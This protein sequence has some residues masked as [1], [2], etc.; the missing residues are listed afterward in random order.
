VAVRPLLAATRTD[1]V[2]LRDADAVADDCAK[3]LTFRATFRPAVAVAVLCPD[4]EANRARTMFGA[5]ETP[6]TTLICTVR[7]LLPTVLT[8]RLLFA[9]TETDRRTVLL[10]T[11]ETPL[12]AVMEQEPDALRDAT[13]VSVDDAVEVA[14]L[15][16]VIRQEVEP[17]ETATTCTIRDFDFSVLADRLL[18]A[19]TATDRPMRRSVAARAGRSNNSCQSRSAFG[20]PCRQ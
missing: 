10:A 1:R 8:D 5:V 11:A 20:E 15:D 4:I 12:V 14:I 17:P 7:D 19:A 3:T 13:T 9:V 2:T 16:R 6:E 18:F